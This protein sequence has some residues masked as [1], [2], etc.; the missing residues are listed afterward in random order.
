MGLKYWSSLSYVLTEGELK[1]DQN[2]I[3]M[4]HAQ[5]GPR[6]G[7]QLKSDQN[8]IEIKLQQVQSIPQEQLKSDQNGI[9]IKLQQVQSIPQE[10]FFLSIYPIV[11][12]LTMNNMKIPVISVEELRNPVLWY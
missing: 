5:T 12:S 11:H 6:R 2:G 9:Q 4:E 10:L 7:P 8:G 3:E 1:S